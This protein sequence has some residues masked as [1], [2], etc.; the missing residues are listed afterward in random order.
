MIE[1]SCPRLG[2]IVGLRFQ[3]FMGGLYGVEIGTS[4]PIGY[5]PLITSKWR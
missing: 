4:V 1:I 5:K 2:T 3:C